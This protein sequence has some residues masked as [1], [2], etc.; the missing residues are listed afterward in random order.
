MAGVEMLANQN[1]GILKD[2][3]DIFVRGKASARA[4]VPHHALGSEIHLPS[5][6]CPA[7]AV[8]HIP[9]L[10]GDGLK[11]RSWLPV[12]VYTECNRFETSIQFSSV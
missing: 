7:F 12:D 1:H 6:K 10:P 5:E 9:R 3:F 8:L 11:G 2:I 4:D